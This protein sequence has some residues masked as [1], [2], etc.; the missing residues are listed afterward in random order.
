MQLIWKVSDKL[1]YKCQDAMYVFAWCFSL[2]CSNE[3][4]DWFFSLISCSFIF[5]CMYLNSDFLLECGLYVFVLCFVHGKQWV[6]CIICYVL[7]HFI[8]MK[9]KFLYYLDFL[10]WETRYTT[11]NYQLL[12]WT[13]LYGSASVSSILHVRHNCLYVFVLYLKA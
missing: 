3:S 8:Q 9:H 10:I 6:I 5:S 7:F 11:S 4:P 1:S 2:A 12:W 13:C